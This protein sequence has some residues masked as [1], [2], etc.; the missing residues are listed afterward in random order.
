MIIA[1][2][3]GAPILYAISKVFGDND[4]V[5][6]RLSEKGLPPTNSVAPMPLG[7]VCYYM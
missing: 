5:N 6:Q 4:L 2:A 3:I 1:I 7:F